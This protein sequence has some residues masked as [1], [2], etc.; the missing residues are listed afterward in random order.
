MKYY[1]GAVGKWLDQSGN[2]VNMTQLT[3]ANKLL[4]RTNQLNS[5]P[6]LTGDGLTKS[7]SNAA[8]LIGTGNVTVFAVIKPRGWGGNNI[9]RIIDNSKFLINVHSTN[10]RLR[11]T[12]DGGTVVYSANS[13]I[14]LGTSYV[15]I[16]TR[17]ATTGLINFYINGVLSGSAD[18]ASGTPATATPTYIGNSTTGVAGF[19]GDIFESGIYSVILSASQIRSLNSYLRNKYTI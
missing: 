6:A 14:A 8:D 4:Y 15:V 11:A 2:T 18:Q 7:L 13:S 5:L 9:G 1:E 19:D 17:T 12:S 10:S 3:Q 16:V